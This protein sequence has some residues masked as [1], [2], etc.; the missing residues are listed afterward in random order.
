MDVLSIKFNGKDSYKDFGLV[1]DGTIV[2][3]STN[4]DYNTENVPGR[5][6]TLNTFKYWN[7]NQIDIKLGFKKD[8]KLTTDKSKILEWLNSK[9]DMRLYISDDM[10]LFYQVNKVS[11]SGFDGREIKSFSVSF[12]LNPFTFLDEGKDIIDI[13]APITICNTRSNL[14]SEPYIKVCGTGNITVKINDFELILKNVSEFI[15]VDSMIKNCYKTV[16]DKK[17][18]CNNLMY[19]GFPIL[20]VGETNISWTGNVTKIEII[21]RWCC[22]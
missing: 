13:Y 4:A 1:I 21:P 17:V 6:G 18:N 9:G 12:S 3:P 22:W 8:S 19:S 11:V 14:E 15:E 20:P 10:S 5:K 2:R 7:D 16:N